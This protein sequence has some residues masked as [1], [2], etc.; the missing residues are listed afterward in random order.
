M[1]NAQFQC[2]T[3][4]GDYL[5]V[6][7]FEDQIEIKPIGP[8]KLGNSINLKAAG[9]RG[10]RDYLSAWLTEREPK[11]ESKP[12]NKL[13]VRTEREPSPPTATYESLVCEIGPKHLVVEGTAPQIARARNFFARYQ[14]D[15]EKRFDDE[16]QP[17]GTY[18]NPKPVSACERKPDCAPDPA[19]CSC[20]PNHL[21][22]AKRV[23][24]IAGLQHEERKA[25]DVFEA[26]AALMAA[27]RLHGLRIEFVDPF[28]R[29]EG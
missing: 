24:R 11:P 22:I 20:D 29:E 6:E 7:D 17:F 27:A 28:K 1:D 10:L 9:I 16:S 2:T 21:E 15:I 26:R 23:L 18:E 4:E 13:V 19:D 3:E 25:P 12:L 14:A 8:L 5:D